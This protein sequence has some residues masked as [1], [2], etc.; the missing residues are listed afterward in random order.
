MRVNSASAWSMCS[1]RKI[2]RRKQSKAQAIARYYALVT[3][4]PAVG[5]FDYLRA[6]TEPGWEKAEGTR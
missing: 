5:L 1:S 6:G 2:N 3:V 4:S